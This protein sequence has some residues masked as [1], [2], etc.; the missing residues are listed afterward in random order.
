VV[1]VTGDEI[2]AFLRA[3]FPDRYC[4]SCLAL[5]VGGTLMETRNL[6]CELRDRGAVLAGTRGCDSCG[7]QLEVFVRKIGLRPKPP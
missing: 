6:L 1:A 3:N 5:K 4:A 2:L 7:R